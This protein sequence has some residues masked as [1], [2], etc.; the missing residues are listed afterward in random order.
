[1]TC[2]WIHLARRCPGTRSSSS[3]A[4]TAAGLRDLKQGDDQVNWSTWG[5]LAFQEAHTIYR[6][7]PLNGNH[8]ETWNTSGTRLDTASS[9]AQWYGNCVD[10]SKTAHYAFAHL[11]QHTISMHTRLNYTVTPELTFEFYGQPFVATG[12]Y[13]NI[14]ELSATPPAA[15]YTERF[16]AYTAP[17]GASPAFTYTQLRTNAVSRWEYRPGS[18]LFL[19][20]S[21]GR[22]DASD[23]YGNQSWTR[24]YR[25]LFALHPDNTLVV[26]AA[27]L[28]SRSRRVRPRAR[29]RHHRVRA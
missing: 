25:D 16:R 7:A 14:R 27:Y 11:R 22:E 18:T 24:D 19:V 5:A 10:G 4:S 29:S 21:H 9:D 17:A 28:F 2:R 6:W 23:Q 3:S 12:N 15:E 26:K 8:W 1:M 20:W 13:S